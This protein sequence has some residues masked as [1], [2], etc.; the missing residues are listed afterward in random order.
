VDYLFINKHILIEDEELLRNVIDF[1]RQEGC[2]TFIANSWN[3]NAFKL[4]DKV[5]IL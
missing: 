1:R 5:I 2:T 4:A 3:M